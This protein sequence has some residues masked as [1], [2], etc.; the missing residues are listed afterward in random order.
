MPNPDDDALQ[1]TAGGTTRVGRYILLETLGEGAFGKVKLAIDSVTG[2]EYAVKVM[3]KA[4]IEEHDLT[5]QV[6]REIAV[7]KAMRHRESK[8]LVIPGV[9]FLSFLKF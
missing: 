1:V 8:Q 4:H 3:E 9:P 7:M 6:R 2:K 5:L